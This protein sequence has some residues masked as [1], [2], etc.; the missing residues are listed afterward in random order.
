VHEHE[1]AEALALLAADDVDL[2]LT[3]DYNLAPASADIT[4]ASIPLWTTA[5][6]LGV[7]AAATGVRGNSSAVIDAFR[8]HDWV[9]NSRNRADEDVIR[10]IASMA[11]FE[12]RITHQSDNLDVVEDLIRNG[13]GVGLLPS[14]RPTP[15]GIT[16]LPLTQPDVRLRAHAH[17]R[18]GRT[19]WPPLALL[20]DRLTA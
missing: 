2:A 16:K 10:V 14:D 17:T 11:G 12:P 4:L 20:L 5:W 7:P 13:I 8:D 9:G 3:Y 19:T 6:S 15:P 18:R 1:P